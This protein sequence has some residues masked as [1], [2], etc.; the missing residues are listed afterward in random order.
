MDMSYQCS[1]AG[2]FVVGVSV[3]QLNSIVLV[4]RQVHPEP[5]AGT[6]LVH[7]VVIVDLAR[8]GRCGKFSRS[9]TE[10][11]A[12]QVFDAHQEAVGDQKIEQSVRGGR[13]N[14]CGVRD[15]LGRCPR[16]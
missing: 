1:L 14:S 8:G 5:D 15:L 3:D 4:R 12:R 13:W 16:T 11:E 10:S 7:D 9:A 6:K 2:Q